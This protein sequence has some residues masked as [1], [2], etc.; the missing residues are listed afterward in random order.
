MVEYGNGIG[1]VSGQAGRAGGG[2]AVGGGGTV[3]GGPNDL[4]AAAADFVSDSVERLMA[5]PPETLVL[6]LV[7]AVVGF[8]FL[9]RAF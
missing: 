1:Q 9:K 8:V 4:G 5:L 2:G 6:M 7:V 3:G